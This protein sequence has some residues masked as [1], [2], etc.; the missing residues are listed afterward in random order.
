[1]EDARLAGES[2]FTSKRLSEKKDLVQSLLAE[3]DKLSDAFDDFPDDDAAKTALY[4]Q[5]TIKPSM[6]SARAVADRLEGMVDHRLW[7]FPTYSEML[8]DHQ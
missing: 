2:G 1:M 4:A 7:P 6:A 5:E 8:H 3:V